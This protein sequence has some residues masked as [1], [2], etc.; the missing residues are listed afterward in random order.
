MKNIFKR[1]VTELLDFLDIFL[2]GL[3]FIGIILLAMYYYNPII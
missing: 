2:T 1:I 3:G